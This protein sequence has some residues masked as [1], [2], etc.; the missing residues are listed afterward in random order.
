MISDTIIDMYSKKK[1]IPFDLSLELHQKLEDF[2]TTAIEKGA[3]ISPT[4]EVDEVWHNLILNTKYYH[5]YCT[6]KF[7]KFIHHTPLNGDC[8]I[9]CTSNCTQNID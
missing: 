9:D 4:K 6:Q 7:G 3:P 2:L 5:E 1:S 8:K